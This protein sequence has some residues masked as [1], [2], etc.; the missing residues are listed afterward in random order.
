M[1]RSSFRIASLTLVALEGPGAPDRLDE[2]L[3]A[4][5][6]RGCVVGEAH[7]REFAVVGLYEL[8]NAG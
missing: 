8:P 4:S 2:D 3:A 7:P 1:L 6:P 5:V